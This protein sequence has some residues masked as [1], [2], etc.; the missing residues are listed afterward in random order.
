[1]A[2][3]TCGPCPSAEASEGGGEA[4]PRHLL[5]ATSARWPRSAPAATSR[6]GT[7]ARDVT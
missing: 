5:G 2:A 3:P 4:R 6:A 1:M 7:R